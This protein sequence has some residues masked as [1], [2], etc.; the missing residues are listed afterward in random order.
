MGGLSVITFEKFGGF[1]PVTLKASLS[2]S[3][4]RS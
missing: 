4:A 1:A 2:V 3:L